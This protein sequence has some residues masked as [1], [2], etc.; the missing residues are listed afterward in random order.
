MVGEMST[1][2]LSQIKTEALAGTEAYHP[3]LD[4]VWSFT[5]SRL[6]SDQRTGWGLW[7]GP[8]FK[9]RVRIGLTLDRAFSFPS[10]KLV[11]V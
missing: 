1:S 2:G 8:I 9:L 5:R 4:L 7:G 11:R 10:A 3:V 6:C